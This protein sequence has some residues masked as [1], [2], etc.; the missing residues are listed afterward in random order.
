M[1]L[2]Y[3]NQLP[4]VKEIKEFFDFIDQIM[5]DLEEFNKAKEEAILFGR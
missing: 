2:S 3:E 5:V 4:S 1:L